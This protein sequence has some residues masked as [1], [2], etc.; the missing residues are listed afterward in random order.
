MPNPNQ[1][2]QGD[3]TLERIEKLPEGFKPVKSKGPHL[4]L[5]EG[6]QSGNRHYIADK[7]VVL[8]VH[9]DG[10]QCL[11]NKSKKA[12]RLKHTADH[13]DLIVSP[14]VHRVGDINEMDHIAQMQRKV[15]D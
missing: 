1:I 13:E 15:V 9:A 10:S 11:V 12:V 3:V 5:R 2:Q 8:Q 14:G 6:S 7:N 4:I